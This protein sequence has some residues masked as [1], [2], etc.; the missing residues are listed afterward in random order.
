MKPSLLSLALI[1]AISMTAC[2][3]GGGSNVKETAPPPPTSPPPPPT[4]PPP[5]TTPPPA[6]K[7]ENPGAINV[8]GELPCKYRYNGAVDNSIVPVNAD[9]AREAG[10][11]G[12][13]VRIG[14]LD[15]ALVQG[16]SALDGV[17]TSNVDFTGKGLDTVPT[18][19]GH[20]NGVASIIAGKAEGTFK[21]GLAPAATIDYA[22]VCHDDKCGSET[23]KT[24]LDSLTANGV[25]IFNLS[26]G[27]F[28]ETADDARYAAEAWDR[29]ARNAIAADSLLVFAAGNSSKATAAMPAG[30]PQYA[31]TMKYN[32]VAVASV[33]VDDKGA[34][35]TLSEYSNACGDASMWC[36]VAPGTIHF[37]GAPGAGFGEGMVGT[38]A[39]NGVVTGVAALVQEAFPWMGGSNLQTTLLT[40]ATDLGDPG[41]DWTYGWNICFINQ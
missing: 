27:A 24:A 38:S 34:V 29:A 33:D 21:G 1:T 14:V 19:N 16:H 23:I 30:A 5:P 7:C 6:A 37:N 28:H 15:D 4:S 17:I 10:Y 31:P 41:V 3:G 18:D 39:A 35:S 9:R 32:V 26:L 11:T 13:G 36:L 22:Q 8:G 25:R 20:G 40:T 12:K 2:G